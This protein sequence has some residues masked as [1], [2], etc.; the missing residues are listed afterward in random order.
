[1]LRATD[2]AGNVLPE[3][4]KVLDIDIKAAAEAALGKELTQN[5][6][7][8][9]FDYDGNL[10][11]ATG[12]FRIYPE[13][14]QQGVLG[15]IA[16][17]AIE[18]ILNGEQADL[19]KAV[20]VYG[21][22]ARR[23]RGKRHCRLQGRCGHPDQ[24]ELLSAA[25]NNGVEVVWCTPYESVGAKVSGEG[26]K[27]TGGGL[28][29]GGGCSPSLTPDLVM[30]TDNADPVKL[31]AL[32]MKTGE[33][34][35]S[36]PVLDDLPEGYQVAVENSAIVYDDSEGTVSTIVCNWFGAGNAGLADPDNDSSIQSYANIYDMNWLTKGNCMIAPGVERVDTVKTDIR[37]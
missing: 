19:S 17:S 20:F 11:F 15:Y 6:L 37:L 24:P 9:V 27:T 30:F 35:A 23:G 5:L 4:E 14:E 29:W 7:S 3:F 25:C 13:R 16:H 22:S 36:M 21:L 10:W 12:G 26:D 2:E 18:A 1:M 34:V 33:I 8:V 31:L 32:D 28:A